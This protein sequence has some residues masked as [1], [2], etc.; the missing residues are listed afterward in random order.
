MLNSPLGAL[1][2]VLAG[3]VLLAISYWGWGHGA[4]A[5]LG[6]RQRATLS[7]ILLL[8][9]GWATALLVFALLH[10]WLPLTA[11]V[12]LPVFAAGLVR[13]LVQAWRQGWRTLL[14]RPSPL[15]LL[16]AALYLLVVVVTAARAMIPSDNYD[17]GL[18]HYGVLTWLES[19]PIVPGLGN[20]HGRLAFNQASLIYI[21]SVDLAPGW[22]HGNV[23]GNSFLYLLVL[24]Q[25]LTLGWPALRQGWPF[26]SSFNVPAIAGLLA[27]PLLTYVAWRQMPYIEA[28]AA[29]APDMATAMLEGALFLLFVSLLMGSAAP[30]WSNPQLATIAVLGVTTVTVKLS[31]GAY[32]LIIA[33]VLAGHAWTSSR[34]ARVP[35][36]A[37]LRL[38][39]LLVLILGT[40]MLRGGILSGCPLYP[41]TVGYWS[42]ADWHVPLAAAQ[43]EAESILVWARA[44]NA[45]WP[46]VLSNWRWLGYWIDSQKSSDGVAYSL[47]VALACLA[48]TAL[49]CRWRPRRPPEKA[50]AV[51]ATT[52]P[53]VYLLPRFLEVLA[54]PAAGLIFWFYTAPEPRFVIALFW[55]LALGAALLLLVALQAR[56]TGALLTAASLVVTA[57]LWGYCLVHAPPTLVHVGLCGWAP[58]PTAPVVP[59]A[60]ASGLLINLPATGEQ[61]WRGVLPTAVTFN[62][63]LRARVPGQ[64][65][66]GFTVQ[67][68]D[69]RMA[70]TPPA[71]GPGTQIPPAT[72]P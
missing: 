31:A 33:L 8:W 51:P 10:L 19:Y 3:Y 43:A 45:P 70:P 32:V 35:F 18:Y 52:A 38:V 17:S 2:Q 27:A 53:P 13:A 42:G 37:A 60:T 21:A 39:V 44:P 65:A 12:C 67:P 64:L 4:A 59:R 14:P 28:L 34:Q 66:A 16:V 20:L 54:A 36:T 22:L 41:A 56:V 24:A 1:A 50:K 9:L 68:A 7:P 48:A 29:P 72:A 58:M 11:T 71:S 46:N 5:M 55:L 61:T 15:F 63:Q 40:W 62:P 30:T 23:L 25:A 26:T 47:Q 49:L 6:L 69:G 57:L